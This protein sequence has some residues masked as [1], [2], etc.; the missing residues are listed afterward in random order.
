MRAPKHRIVDSNLLYISQKYLVCIDAIINGSFKIIQNT[1][2]TAPQ[3]NG[4]HRISTFFI[5]DYSHLLNRPTVVREFSQKKTVVRED[6]KMK[7]KSSLK[8]QKH[9]TY[10]NIPNFFHRNRACIS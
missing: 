5:L 4:G 6:T 10:S 1:V 7:N 9:K 8:K 2:S 3:H